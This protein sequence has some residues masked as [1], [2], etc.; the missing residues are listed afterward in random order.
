MLFI[1]LICAKNSLR[2][3]FTTDYRRYRIPSPHRPAARKC[4][5]R[6]AEGQV[7]PLVGRERPFPSATRSRQGRSDLS[8]APPARVIIWSSTAAGRLARK[9]VRRHRFLRTGL[10]AAFSVVSRALLGKR[11]STT[12]GPRAF[13]VGHFFLFPPPHQS[14]TPSLLSLPLPPAA[15][16]PTVS[17]TS[18]PIGYRSVLSCAPIASSAHSVFATDRISR[19][20]SSTGRL[21]ISV[22]LPPPPCYP[23]RSFP[24]PLRRLDSPRYTGFN[25]VWWWTLS[26]WVAMR[27]ARIAPIIVPPLTPLIGICCRPQSTAAWLSDLDHSAMKK[28]G[29]VWSVGRLLSALYRQL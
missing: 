29:A 5:M 21:L 9:T 4:Q 28:N 6:I 11:R 15:H 8:N 23:L 7:V 14:F 19:D 1:K 2:I 18:I 12:G 10:P 20:L 26:A 24:L 16:R 25:S 27:R 3:L 13:V 17:V 22:Q